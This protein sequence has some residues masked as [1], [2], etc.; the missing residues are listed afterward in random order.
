MFDSE[1][2]GPEFEPT[3]KE[4]THGGVELNAKGTCLHP[5][6]RRD[7]VRPAEMLVEQSRWVMR[8]A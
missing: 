3:D 5:L 8:L 4:G 2:D 6:R 1:S 7:V